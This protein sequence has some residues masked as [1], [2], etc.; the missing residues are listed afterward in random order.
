MKLCFIIDS[1]IL[2]KLSIINYVT[3]LIYYFDSS[4]HKSITHLVGK[5]VRSQ[6]D[7]DNTFSD[8]IIP[9]SSGNVWSFSLPIID[10]F[11]RAVKEQTL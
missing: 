11:S 2:S 10:N 9:I 5:W 7:T 8:F 3:S 6:F 1:C 4:D